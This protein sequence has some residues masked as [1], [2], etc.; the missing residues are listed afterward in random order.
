[1]EKTELKQREDQIVEQTTTFCKS[2]IDTEYTALCRKMARKLG[3]NS[4]KPFARGRIEI[5]AAAIIYTIGSINFLFDKSFAPY[6]SSSTI[7]EYFG[8][9]QTSISHKAAQI[10]KMLNMSYYFDKDFSTRYMR[11]SNPL[12]LLG[13]AD[14]LFFP[15][16]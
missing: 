7:H 14:G 6:I 11:E 5:W 4:A 1:M 8:T 3:S 13:M 10:R 16:E 12:N 15:G 2:N 9:K